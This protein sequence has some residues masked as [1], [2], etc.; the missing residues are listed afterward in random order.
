[1]IP[2]LTDRRMPSG[3]NVFLCRISCSQYFLRG[4]DEVSCEEISY[5]GDELGWVRSGEYSSW[6]R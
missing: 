5:C 6:T 1:M 3:A 4:S 2:I